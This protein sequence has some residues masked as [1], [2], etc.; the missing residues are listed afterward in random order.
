MNVYVSTLTVAASLLIA[1]QPALA[2]SPASPESFLASEENNHSQSQSDC[3]G[4]PNG[5]TPL[6]DCGCGKPASSAFAC[7]VCGDDTSCLDCAGVPFGGRQPTGPTNGVPGADRC[8]LVCPQNSALNPKSNTCLT[9]AD[10]SANL[11]TVKHVYYHPNVV[12]RVNVENAFKAKNG[13]QWSA[14]GTFA[15]VDLASSCLGE[16]IDKCLHEAPGGAANLRLKSLLVAKEQEIANREGGVAASTEKILALTATLQDLEKSIPTLTGATLDSAKRS[17]TA[18]QALLLAERKSKTAQV[19]ALQVAR[20]AKVNLEKLLNQK[21]Q[22][23]MI[24][25]RIAGDNADGDTCVAN[26][27]FAWLSGLRT[28]GDIAELAPKL[29]LA[30]AKISELVAQIAFLK[31]TET[32]LSKSRNVVAQLD[33]VRADLAQKELELQRAELE[34][35]NLSTATGFQGDTGNYRR[36]DLFGASVTTVREVRGYVSRSSAGGCGPVDRDLLKVQ[37]QLQ[38]DVQEISVSRFDSPVSLLWSPEVSIEDITSFAAF[39]LDGK[40]N[41]KKLFQWRASGMTPLVV[42]D[43]TGL[44]EIKDA[45]Q[46]FGNYTFGK[47]WKNGYDALASLDIDKSGWLEGEELNAVALWFDV[48]QDGV[49]QKGE[50]KRLIDTS[51]FAIGVK[52]DRVDEKTKSIFASSGFKRRVDGKEI[53]GGSVDWFSGPV[54]G[55]L[56]EL[57]G[58]A[59][60]GSAQNSAAAPAARA[61]L[62]AAEEFDVVDP[63]TTVSGI[64]QWHITDDKTLLP[65]QRPGGILALTQEGETLR[66]Q[67]FSAVQFRPNIYGI[68]EEISAASITGSFGNGDVAFQVRG[69]KGPSASSTAKLSADGMM[70]TG[71]TTEEVAVEGG[72]AQ[73]TFAWEARRLVRTN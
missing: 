21:R 17:K 22:Y 61:D 70:L 10:V 5:T 55:E 8:S 16:A 13:N 33:K 58:E 9:C 73:V 25:R 60:G 19:A 4:I 53:V 32:A 34:R 20:N 47:E 68:Y 35:D 65:E 71:S 6:T 43:S 1:T 54:K 56:P 46:L 39:P 66:G 41:E 14:L 63:S 23:L 31:K 15:Q 30:N 45:T 72:T 2:Q 40:S 3:A 24:A 59:A 36:S 38:C 42:Y 69:S 51:V 11:M 52:S 57:L 64:W 50:V 27:V 67:S 12:P 7:K 49:S 26:N 18:T 29:V 48:N 44:G 62:A 37:Q 28:P